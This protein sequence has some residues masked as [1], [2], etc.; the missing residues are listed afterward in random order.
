V[1]EY[2]VSSKRYESR[3]GVVKLQ[4]RELSSQSRVDKGNSTVV[5]LWP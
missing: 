2:R 4:T 5:N 3:D 1:K